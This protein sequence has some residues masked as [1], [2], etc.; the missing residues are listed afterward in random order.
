MRNFPGG[1][2][3]NAMVTGVHVTNLY[4]R[5]L[6]IEISLSDDYYSRRV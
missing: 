5:V 3:F 2:G 4:V 1:L 6:Y